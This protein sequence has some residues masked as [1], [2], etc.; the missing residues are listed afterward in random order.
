MTRPLLVI[1]GGAPATGKT[2][3]ARELARR[4]H[5]AILTKDDIKESLADALGS[6]DRTRSRELGRAAYRVLFDVT[7]RTLEAGTGVVL[8]ANFYRDD[9]ADE[10]RRLA[11]LGEA[12]I[13]LCRSD[14]ATRRARFETRRDRHPVHLDR[15]ILAHEWPDDDAKFALDLGVPR[16]EVDTTRAADVDLDAIVAWISSEVSSRTSV[17]RP[18]D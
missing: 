3:L 1:V 14:A 2:T 9:S 7:A 4:L 6:G 13:V 5:L 18:V 16:R 12:V 10:L 15:E 17:R 8:E 11:R